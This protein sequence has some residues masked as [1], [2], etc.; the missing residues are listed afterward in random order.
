MKVCA[1]IA[2]VLIMPIG[3]AQA[4]HQCTE[5]VDAGSGRRLV[6]D[7]QC[8]QRVTSGSTFKVAIS[9][10]GYDSGILKDEHRPLLP[11]RPGYVDWQPS[12]RQATDPAAWMERS[13][14]W[15]SQ[16]VTRR[17]GEARFR[18]YVNAFDYGNKDVSGDPGKHNGLS[19]SWISSSLQ[20]SPVEQVAFLGKLVNRQLGVKPKA[21]AM[22]ARI[23]KITT[24]GDG[25]AIYGKS[26]TGSPRDGGFSYG[27][28]VGWASKGER[29]IV[30]AR[31]VQ[32]ERDEEELAGRRVKAAFLRELPAKLSQF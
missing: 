27:W 8:E 21:Y 30:F 18:R 17:L 23:M 32:D 5:M 12:W 29:T 11:F 9:L 16:Q 10:M 25:W 22:T 14:V 19:T 3:M 13:V 4:A 26:G 2:A 24:T 15:Y 1:A 20:I 6:H 28:F 31:L 7:G